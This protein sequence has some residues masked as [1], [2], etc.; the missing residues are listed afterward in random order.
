[1]AAKTCL[2][3]VR[4]RQG[5]FEPVAFFGDNLDVELELLVIKRGHGLLDEP[6]HA[7]LLVKGEGH[8]LLNPILAP[9]HGRQNPTNTDCSE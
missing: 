3:R 7:V 8:E 1:M 6:Y 2:L 4:A 5:I 9:K